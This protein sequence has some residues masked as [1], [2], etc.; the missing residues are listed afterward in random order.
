[1]IS[2]FFEVIMDTFITTS[3]KVDDEELSLR[4]TTKPN[5]ATAEN[6]D[7]AQSRDL[8]EG[9]SKSS[10]KRI[11]TNGNGEKIKHAEQ[12]LVNAVVPA[13]DNSSGLAA[14]EVR[15]EKIIVDSLFSVFGA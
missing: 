11:T 6:T 10:G 1:M 12:D 3:K 15:L 2:S 8:A 7:E 5:D 9:V 13:H 4:D 14:R